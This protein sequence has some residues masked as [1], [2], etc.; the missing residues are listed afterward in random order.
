MD[1]QDKVVVV[2]GGASG[3]GA[4][5]VRKFSGLGARVCVAD[6]N[7]DAAQGLADQVGGMAMRCDVTSESD[8]VALCDGVTATM[9]PID[10]FVSNAG[11]G[12]G[13]PGHAASASNETWMLNWNVHVMAHVY[14]ARALLPQMIERGSGYFV[15]VASAAGLLNQ[16]GDAA[17]SATK[18]A[19]VSFAESLAIS[20]GNDGIGVS[21]L[22][23]QYVATPLIDLADADAAGHPSLMTADDVAQATVDGINN[24]QF[25]ILSHP[26]V[27]EY[28]KVRANDPDA[29]LEGM[30]RLKIKAEREL[31]LAGIKDFYKLV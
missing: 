28:V 29:W 27:G 24:K 4:A 1:F 9:G 16:I 8:I 23:P 18:H 7:M 14:A 22:C 13:Q 5:M 10:L 6:L 31:G 15:N 2:T 20:H 25:R 26:V 3:I 12:R 11:L 30:R 17:Y 19:A 21:V